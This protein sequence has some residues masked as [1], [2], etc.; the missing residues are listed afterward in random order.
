MKKIAF[1]LC[2][3]GLMSSNANASEQAAELKLS[4][5]LPVQSGEY[6]NPY[7]AVWIE[8]SKGQSV[9]TIALWR[10]GA[11]WLKD[12]RR[13]WRKVG[14]KDQALVDAMTS[15]TRAA[16]QYQLKIKA[17]NDKQQPLAP[18]HYVLHIEVVRENGGRAITKQDFELDGKEHS[19]TLA[20]NPEMA[21]SHFYIK[22]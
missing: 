14:R 18:G 6:H 16:G 9:R 19:F 21:Q 3:V 11:K 1:L 22:E 13:W 12:I 7:V 20:S 2:L 8:D 5:N 4:L 15:A 17:L 10:E